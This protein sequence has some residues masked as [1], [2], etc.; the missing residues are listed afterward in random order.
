M[1]SGSKMG[2]SLLEVTE[3]RHLEAAVCPIAFGFS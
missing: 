1:L 2:G 3:P